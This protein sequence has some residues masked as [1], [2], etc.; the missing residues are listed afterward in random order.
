MKILKNIAV[1][2]LVSFMGS[3]PLGYL[4]VIGFDLYQQTNLSKLLWYLT[5]VIF[6]EAIVI[7]LTLLFAEKLSQKK[8]LLKWIEG[9]SVIFMFILAYIFHSSSSADGTLDT[10]LATYVTYPGILIG[11]IFSCLNF[12]QIPF[13][14]AWNMYLLNAGY[15]SLQRYDRLFYVLGTIAGTF[16]GM[17]LLIMFLGY[18]T[19]ESNFLS[20]Y[21]MRWIIPGVFTVL[22]LYQAYK[23]YRKYYVS[24]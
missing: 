20:K 13:W 14:M 24:A 2:F 15:I 16:A 10:D 4:N 8:A 5:G 21:L 17:L 23:F 1:G 7:F 6:I 19:D 3:I 22:G 12:I 11:I 18:I 9:F